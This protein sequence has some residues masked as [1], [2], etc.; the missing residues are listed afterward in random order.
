MDT[1]RHER[2]WW[3]RGPPLRV[4]AEIATVVAGLASLIQ[5]LVR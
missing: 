3:Q 2:K 4:L 1:A 5:M